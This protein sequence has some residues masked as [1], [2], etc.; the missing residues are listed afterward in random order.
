MISEFNSFLKWTRTSAQICSSLDGVHISVRLGLFNVSILCFR[1]ASFVRSPQKT[2]HSKLGFFEF[3]ESA[4]AHK[5]CKA[6]RALLWNEI[7]TKAALEV[8]FL[9]FRLRWALSKALTI[10]KTHLTKVKWSKFRFVFRDPEILIC[11][12]ICAR[13]LVWKNVLLLTLEKLIF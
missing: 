7:K 6:V 3:E 2:R 10:N 5:Y 13:F 12:L 4:N 8:D 11:A 1:C 9:M